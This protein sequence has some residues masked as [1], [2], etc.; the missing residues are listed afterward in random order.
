MHCTLG[1]MVIVWVFIHFKCPVGKKVSCGR[2]NI[3]VTHSLCINLM[4]V[5]E[6]YFRNVPK[7]IE[8]P[9]SKCW[10]LLL[11]V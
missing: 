11:V 1:R 10:K 7:K 3:A 9:Y 2:V 6:S 8:C 5:P 4:S